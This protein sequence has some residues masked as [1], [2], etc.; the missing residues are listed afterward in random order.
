[1]IRFDVRAPRAEAYLREHSAQLVTRIIDDQRQAIRSVLETGLIEG[2]N[3]R[4]TALDI[5]GRTSRATNS[6]TGGLIG[7]SAPQARAVD[8]ARSGLI[9]GDPTAMREYLNLS[10]R[11]RRFDST[12]RKAIAEGK[13]LSADVVARITGRYSDRLLQLRGETIA[14]TETLGALARSK[15]EAFRQAIDTGAV[16]ATQVKKVWQA[17]LDNRTRDSHA[18][19]NG[20][21]VGLND[22]FSN[23]LLYPHEDGAPASEVISCRCSYDH[24]IDFLAGLE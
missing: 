3:P 14:R 11:D 9:S 2:R 24:V 15:E 19:V 7:L 21:R 20:E 16:Q 18:G 8:N 17:T 22:R 6:R 13:A 4:N 12:V 5:I 1:V 10:R 23:G